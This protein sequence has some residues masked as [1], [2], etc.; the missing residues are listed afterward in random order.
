MANF[1]DKSMDINPEAIKKSVER[2]FKEIM[3]NPN[4][5]HIKK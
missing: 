3:S 2:A 1:M 4:F 5:N